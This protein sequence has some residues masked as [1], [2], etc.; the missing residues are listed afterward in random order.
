MRLSLPTAAPAILAAFALVLVSGCGDS[1]DGG[2]AAER[3]AVGSNLT[4]INGEVPP[5][6]PT[7]PKSVRLLDVR[8]GVGTQIQVFKSVREAGTRAPIHSHPYGGFSCVSS[9]EIT[10]YMEGAKPRIAKAGDCYWMPPGFAMSAAS[11]GSI[12][13]VTIDY[14]ATPPGEKVWEVDE[15][16]LG[17]LQDQFGTDHSH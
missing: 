16:G 7:A 8:N 10:F 2:S 11:A 4:E 3:T 5:G 6:R 17:R 1:N 13:S 9:G 12:G 15:K 14:F